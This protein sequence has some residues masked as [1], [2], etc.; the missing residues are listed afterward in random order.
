MSN[1]FGI[2]LSAIRTLFTKLDVT[3]NNIANANTSGLKKS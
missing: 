1:A 2:A 3:A